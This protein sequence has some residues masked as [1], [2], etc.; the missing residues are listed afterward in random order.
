MSF[1]VEIQKDNFVKFAGRLP[2]AHKRAMASAISS[3]SYRLLQVLRGYARSWGHGSW[4]PFSPV[5]RHL[6]KGRGYGPWV[7]RFSNYSVDKEN[8][9]ARIGLLGRGTVRSKH[10]ISRAFET[11]ALQLAGGYTMFITGRQQRQI[12]RR[13]LRPGGKSFARVKTLRGAQRKYDRLHEI[14][15]RAGFRR[16]KARPFAE[17]VLR[18]ERAR[19]IRNIGQL[20]GLKISGQRYAR[21][22]A[23]DWGNA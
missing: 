7:A 3:E 15:P 13:L 9:S 20:Y 1:R 2:E 4:Q 10:A 18:Q 16:V 8:L 17:P 19:T 11:S 23:S 6:R 12:A 22:W 14:I 5:T 21:G